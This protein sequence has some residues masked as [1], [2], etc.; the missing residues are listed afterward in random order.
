M[1][2]FSKVWIDCFAKHN[3]LTYASAVAFQLL[4][5]LVPLVVLT[6]GLLGALDEQTVWKKQISPGIERRLP[7]PTWDAVN[8]AAERILSHATVGLIIFGIALA[9]WELSGAVR[10]TM[11][12]LNQMYDTDE[13][14]SRYLRVATSVSG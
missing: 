7:G 10:A 5:A 2:T 11:G 3:I 9:I 1:C 13:Q 8:Y 14:R 12:A 4:I 6:L